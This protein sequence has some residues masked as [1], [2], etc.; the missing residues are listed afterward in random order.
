MPDN[1]YGPDKP[2]QRTKCIEATL[3]EIHEKTIRAHARA[4]NH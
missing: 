3:G 4:W 2:C 1:P